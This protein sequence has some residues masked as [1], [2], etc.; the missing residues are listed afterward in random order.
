MP[1]E[2]PRG[3]KHFFL[4][5]PRTVGVD[6]L[7]VH[8]VR[9]YREVMQ[10]A[11]GCA[12]DQCMDLQGGCSEYLEFAHSLCILQAHTVV[13]TVQSLWSFDCK[14]VS[15]AMSL[16][17]RLRRVR[18]AVAAPCWQRVVFARLS[19]RVGNSW[20]FRQFVGAPRGFGAVGV[21]LLARCREVVPHA[22]LL[23]CCARSAAVIPDMFCTARVMLPC[24][25]CM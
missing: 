11:G 25:V 17:R 4:M 23:R 14:V 12:R 6:S 1:S 10:R 21:S 19:V 3:S 16:P 7:H 5:S 15:Y 24:H 18:L 8:W 13:A 9:T 22:G 2:M 20:C